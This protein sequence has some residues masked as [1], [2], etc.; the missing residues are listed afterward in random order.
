[1]SPEAP[2]LCMVGVTPENHNLIM[3]NKQEAAN[4]TLKFNL[5][6]EGNTSN[7]FQKIGEI[8]LNQSFTFNDSLVNAAVK[9]NR[10]AIQRTD[11]C[12]LNS[13]IS[14]PHQTMHL[15]INKGVGTSWNL[16]WNSYVGFN[17]SINTTFRGCVLS[18]RN[19]QSKSLRPR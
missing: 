5:Y 17:V 13:Q 8:A 7:N 18:G 15:T 6:K 12:N 3:W 11:L 4:A 9:S 19:Y 10:Y 2:K 1:M 14:S 16:I